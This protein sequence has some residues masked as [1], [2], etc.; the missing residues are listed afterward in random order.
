VVAKGNYCVERYR[1]HINYTGKMMDAC[2]HDD[3]LSE[4]HGRSTKNINMTLM[5]A[6]PQ[7]IKSHITF[8]DRCPPPLAISGIHVVKAKSTEKRRLLLPLRT[9]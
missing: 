6:M 5:F 1:M 3:K 4:G 8:I 2:V 7:G 9:H